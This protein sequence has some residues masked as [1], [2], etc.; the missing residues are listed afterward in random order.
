MPQMWMP[1]G[2]RR[3]GIT[4]FRVTVIHSHSGMTTGTVGPVYLTIQLSPI[5]PLPPFTPNLLISSVCEYT[6]FCD[7]LSWWH[8]SIYH[9]FLLLILL[10]GSSI[11]LHR[12]IPSSSVPLWNPNFNPTHVRRIYAQLE[13]WTVWRNLEEPIDLTNMIRLITLLIL[14]SYCVLFALNDNSLLIIIFYTFLSL[15][16]LLRQNNCHATKKLQRK[17]TK[18][19]HWHWRLLPLRPEFSHS[20]RW[21]VCGWKRVAQIWDRLPFSF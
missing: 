2:P 9:G 18:K 12:A 8:V 1:N 7:L 17:C 21:N 15:L 14:T 13:L 5:H 3:N 11:T 16:K 6:P 20:L 10:L 4:G 19:K